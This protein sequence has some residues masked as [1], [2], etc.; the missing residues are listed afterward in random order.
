MNIEKI[1]INKIKKNPNNPRVLRDEKFKK[2][3][4]SIQDFPE[5]LEIRPIVINDDFT[6]LWWNMRLEACKKAWLS[7]VFI[8]KASNLTEEQQKE[9]IIKDNISFWDWDYDIL[10]NEW[11]ASELQDWGL[12]LNFDDYVSENNKD[13]LE[14]DN[15]ND[16]EWEFF[17]ILFKGKDDLKIF[18]WFLDY[19][20]NN[21]SWKTNWERIIDFIKKYEG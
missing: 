4:K 6:V 21:F 10:A 2:L 15:N 12:Y 3:V 17:E 19:L 13:E 8:I 7:E 14:E 16:N 18:L 11:D 20:K 1:D 5:M 9:F